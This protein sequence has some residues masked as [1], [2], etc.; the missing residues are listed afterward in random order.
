MVFLVRMRG[1]E[2]P[3][4]HHHRLLRP[5]RLPVPPHPQKY[6]H[7][8][9]RTHLEGVKNG[10]LRRR[11]SRSRSKSRSRFRRV[12]LRTSKS[13]FLRLRRKKRSEDRLL[14][15]GPRPSQRPSLASWQLTNLPHFL[16]I[17][18]ALRP[19]PCPI[20]SEDIA[21]IINKPSTAVPNTF[22]EIENFMNSSVEI[23]TAEVHGAS[24]ATALGSVKATIALMLMPLLPAF[25][26][27]VIM[28][29]YQ[30][31]C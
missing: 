18:A 11:Q 13:R 12:R 16:S 31:G 25:A 6:R 23:D 8:I 26:V 5:A 17:C 3:R 29:P 21:T 20:A 22:L 27:W 10:Y 24:G 1:L 14:R 7:V 15:F 30:P 4:C 9:M 28:I 2:P 19:R